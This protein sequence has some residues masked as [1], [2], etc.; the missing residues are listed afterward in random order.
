MVVPIDITFLGTGSAQPSETRNHQSIAFR[1]NGDI[2]LFDAGEATQHQLQKSQLKMGRITKVF[3]THL[4]GDHCFGLAPLLCS[5]TENLNPNRQNKEGIVDIYGPSPLRRWLR[6]TLK[7]TYSRLGRRYRVHEVLLDES[8]REI[9]PERAAD[10]HEDEDG[11]V[12]DVLLLTGADEAG[13]LPHIPNGWT[14]QAAPIQHSIPSLGYVISEP[15]A[16]GKLDKTTIEPLLA[17]NAEALKGQGYKHPHQILGQLQKPN[18][19]PLQLPDG[20]RIIPPPPRPGRIIVIL[21]DTCDPTA[22]IPLLNKRRP[23]VLVHEA[24][25]A[26]T[27]LDPPTLSYDEVKERAVAHGHSTPQMAAQVAKVMGAR[28]LLLT[29]FSVRYRGDK[30]GDEVMEEIRKQAVTVL[31]EERNDDVHCARDFW[32]Y[33]V[34]MHKQFD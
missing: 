4:H 8:E 6:T 26:L 2:W 27:R 9:I 5:M 34:K 32:S 30:E 11:D 14:V 18:A 28:T 3:I 10:L 19:K 31:G 7:S 13:A 24:T 29:H 12:C 16:P 33:Q 20:S 23:D 1:A 17:K 25:N 22:I 21:G 15:E